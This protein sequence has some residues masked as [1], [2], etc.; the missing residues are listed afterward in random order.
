MN[1]IIH[2]P[3]MANDQ[4]TGVSGDWWLEC[5]FFGSAIYKSRRLA[6]AVNRLLDTHFL[7]H[8]HTAGALSA[9]SGH[10]P[11]EGKAAIR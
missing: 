8:F 7:A 10:L 2:N 11:L 9:P 6:A 3:I 1:M 5:H 4:R